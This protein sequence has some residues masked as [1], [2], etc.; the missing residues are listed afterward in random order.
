MSDALLTQI[1]REIASALPEVVRFRH[2]RHGAPEL[3]WQEKETSS[4][5]VAALSKIPQLEVKTNVGR[6]GIVA[7]LKGKAD[8]PTVALRADM[9]ALPL[10]EKTGLPYASRNAGTMHACGHD[11]HMAGLLG[12]AIVLSRLQSQLSGT[13]KFFFQPAEEGG[14]GAR[15]MCDDGALKGV[16]AIFGLHGWPELPLGTIYIKEGPFMAAHAEVHVTVR[17]KGCHAAMPHLGTDQILAAAKFIEAVQ[18]LRS[19]SFSP[20]EPFLLTLA[21]IHGGHATNVIPDEVKLTGT[22][23]TLT[24]TAQRFATGEM[25]KIARG[26]GEASGT[27]IEVKITPEYPAVINHPGATRYLQT[28]AGKVLGEAGVKTMPSPV[29]TAEDFSFFLERAPGSFFFLGLGDGRAGGYPSLHSSKFDFNDQGL[30]I[31]MRLF[32]RLALESHSMKI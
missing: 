1:D 32:T 8:G 26:V 4:A 25:E 27:T 31:A 5:V 20:V 14:A 6:L 28:V 19:R 29:M 9:D 18:S 15:A 30:P 23:R 12:S 10:E 22:M 21:S 24:P 17:G 13:V 2:E 7:T 16:D 11:G 3:T